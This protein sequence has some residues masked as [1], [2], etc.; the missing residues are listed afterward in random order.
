MKKVY[1]HCN[2]KLFNTKSGMQTFLIAYCAFPP[3]PE[4]SSAELQWCRVSSVSCRVHGYPCTAPGC[5]CWY[6]VVVHRIQN[7]KRRCNNLWL[8]CMDNIHPRVEP[9]LPSIAQGT[10]K[11]YTYKH[12]YTIAVLTGAF[13]SMGLMTNFLSLKEIFLMS[14]HGNPIFGV[15]LEK[16]NGDL[17]VVVY[18]TCLGILTQAYNLACV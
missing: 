17:S 8:N 1:P 6:E 2:N 4:L 18:S 3:G 11:K 12:S 14:L 5:V 7:P 10:N 13:L 15:S 16:T 9:T